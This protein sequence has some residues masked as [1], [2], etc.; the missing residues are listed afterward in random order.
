MIRSLVSI[1]LAEFLECSILEAF[2]DHRSAVSRD[3]FLKCTVD[4]V[5]SVETVS[6]F[7]C[8]HRTLRPLVV[9]LRAVALPG[10]GRH[11]TGLLAGTLNTCT[12][13]NQTLF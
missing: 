11:G 8:V 9:G 4:C 5:G 6:S 10:G 2:T 7:M 13:P 1:L 12:F 3:G